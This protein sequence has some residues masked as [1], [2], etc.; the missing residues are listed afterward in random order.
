MN[1]NKLMKADIN[2][3]T[4][5]DHTVIA[6][7]TDGFIAIEHINLVPTTSTTLQFKDGVTNYG[8]AYALAN[9]QSLVLENSIR[10]EDGLMQMSSKSAFGINTGSAVQVSGFVL[11]RI[12]I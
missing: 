3:A 11:Y 6:A 7:P 5:G 10:N 12:I 2:F 1:G 8:G 9:Q 4:S